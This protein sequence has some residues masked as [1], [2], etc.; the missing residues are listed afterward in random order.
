MEWKKLS[1][2]FN[3][4]RFLAISAILFYLGL[5]SIS[6]ISSLTFEMTSKAFTHQQD[7]L[8]NPFQV[9]LCF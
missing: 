8:V 5:T 6:I 1:L 3:V 7:F 4:L 2:T 9:Y